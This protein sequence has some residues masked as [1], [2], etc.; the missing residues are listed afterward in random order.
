MATPVV[1]VA[2]GGL[3]VI[4]VTA[5]FP[6]LGLPVTEAFAGRG[7]AITKVASGGLP[8]TFSTVADYP[9]PVIPF[10]AVAWDGATSTNVTLSNSNRTVTTTGGSSGDQGARVANVSGKTTGKH[11]FECTFTTFIGGSFNTSIGVA[12]TASSFVN[13][14]N[15]NATG[16]CGVFPQ[17]SSCQIFVNNGNSGFTLGNRAA[18]DILGVA[19]D[20]TARKIWFRVSPS[21]NWNGQAIGLQ[22]PAAGIGGIAIPAGTMIPI[23]TFSA[24]GCIATTNFGNAAFSGAVPTGYA[25]GWA[26]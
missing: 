14:G 20:L 18:G 1:T 3:P 15:S 13:F 26:V 2:S 21:G 11:Y 9:P 22:D 24:T 10:S 8:V 19:V 6:K 25:Q 5:T 7:I 12:T 4:D 17:T 16:G 23:S